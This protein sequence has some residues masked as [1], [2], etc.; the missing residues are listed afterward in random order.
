M[1]RQKAHRISISAIRLRV[2]ALAILFAL[3]LVANPWAQAQTYR[4]LYNFTDG[5][6]GAVPSAGLLIDRAGN[7]YGTA[8]YGGKAGCRFGSCGTVFKLTHKGSGWILNV[9]YSFVGGN[10]GFQP[11]AP[12][13]LGPDGSLYGTTYYGGGSGGPYQTGFGTIFKLQPPATACKS[14]LCPWT[15]TQLY[16]F[17]GGSDGGWPTTSGLIFDPAGNIYGTTRRPPGGKWQRL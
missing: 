15:E 3:P 12:L 16:S 14:A 9:L 11:L 7:L 1:T 5:A 17:T 2:A 10:D 4:V 8:A 6:D 13:A